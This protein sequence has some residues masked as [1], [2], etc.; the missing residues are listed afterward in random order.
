MA[1]SVWHEAEIKSFCYTLHAHR[2]V[3]ALREYAI[4]Y[5]LNLKRGSLY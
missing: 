1:N 4:Q 3:H 2:S 5:H